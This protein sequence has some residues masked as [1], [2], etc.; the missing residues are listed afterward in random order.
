[1]NLNDVIIAPKVT[2][3]SEIGKNPQENVTRYVFRVHAKANKELIR[4]ALHH[5]YKVN[6]V[7]INTLIRRGKIKRFRATKIRL[8]AQKLAVVTL[9]PNQTIDL[10]KNG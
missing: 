3:K 4:Q 7:K 8:S 2:E 1:M 10:V 9:A 5:L 6:A